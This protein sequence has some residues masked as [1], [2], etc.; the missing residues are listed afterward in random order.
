MAILDDYNPRDTSKGFVWLK[1]RTDLIDEPAFMQLTDQAKAIYFEVYFLAGKSDAGGLILTGDKP[2]SIGNLAWLLR[3]QEVDVQNALDELDRAGL[4][5]LDNYQ[6]TVC[7]FKNE[8]GP[9]M[10]D[11]RVQW[12]TRQA[13]RRARARGEVWPEPDANAEP[14]PDKK[15][16]REGSKDLKEPESEQDKDL[17]TKTKRVTDQ[18][19]DNHAGVTRDKVGGGGLGVTV[20]SVLDSWQ[21]ITGKKFARNAVF[22]TMI[23]YWQDEG[24]SLDHVRQAIL[25]A[26]DKAQTPHYLREIAVNIKNASPEGQAQ[27]DL[28]YWRGLYK[29]N[30]TAEGDE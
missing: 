26:K 22:D 24:V 28:D 11:Q 15:Q 29:Q 21:A 20:Q 27:K 2:A 6:V 25:E 14:E 10:T 17:K 30:H 23:E 13:K 9:S 3:R 12:A 5:D 19:R 18:S 1:F 16:N 7:R 4:V 8:Q